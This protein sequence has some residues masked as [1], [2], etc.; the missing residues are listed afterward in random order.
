MPA[1]RPPKYE[2]A[3]QLQ[4]AI[5]KYFES[6]PLLTITGLCLHLGF[7]SRQSFY[8]LQKNEEF[9]YTIKKARMRIESAYEELL[10]SKAFAG[11]IFAL[12]NF[13]W[14]DKQTIEHE[15]GISLKPVIINVEG[16]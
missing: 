11:A 4:E 1:G 14:T 9:S 13:G 3:E 8:D 2:S 12:K 6:T 7:E 16:E 10:Q 5:D 15:G